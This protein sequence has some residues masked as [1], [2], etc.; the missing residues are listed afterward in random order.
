MLK[1]IKP[2]FGAIAKKDIKIGTVIL[3]EKPQIQDMGSLKK[4][5]PEWIKSVM[6]SFNQMTK[7]DQDEFLKMKKLPDQIPWQLR[8]KLQPVIGQ[9]FQVKY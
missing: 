3:K 9:T 2:R 6:A 8:D 4:G 1:T 5:I 7:V